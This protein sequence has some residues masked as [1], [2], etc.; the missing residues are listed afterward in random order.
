MTLF[1]IL[2]AGLAAFLWAT[3][4]TAQ[5]YPVKP[6]RVV[7]GSPPGGIDAYIRLIGPKVAETIGQPVIIENRGG[8]GGTL[9]AAEAAKAAPDG[10]TLLMGAIHHTIA[11]SVYPKLSYDLRSTRRWSPS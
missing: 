3:S 8:A 5:S 9:G 11:A 10:Y 1:Q 4:A 7:V 6:V 2:L